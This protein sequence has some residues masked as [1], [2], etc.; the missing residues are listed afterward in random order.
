MVMV[1]AVCHNVLLVVVVVMMVVVVLSVVEIAA[2][3]EEGE[4]G[5]AGVAGVSGEGVHTSLG[6]VAGWVGRGA[7]ALV[8]LVRNDGVKSARDLQARFVLVLRAWLKESRLQVCRQGALG[9]GGGVVRRMAGLESESQ[10]D[11]SV[12]ISRRT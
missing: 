1:D 7:A 9:F 10:Q 2:D 8:L 4:E 12:S 3:K 6:N 5:E 11:E